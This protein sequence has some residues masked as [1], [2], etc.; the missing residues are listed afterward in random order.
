MEPV[1]VGGVIVSRATLHNEDEI[2]KKDI[3]LGDT[4][5]I[6]RAGDVIPE[7]IK[8]VE[9]KRNGQ[10]KIFRMPSHCPQCGSEISACRRSPRIAG[11]PLLSSSNKEH[12]GISPHV[13][14][15]IFE[16]LGE[17]VSAQLFDAD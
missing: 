3:R 17:K 12:T 1:S 11:Q 16:D 9:S 7:V 14:R 5:V 10:E 8:I 13:A 4:V 6:Q 2:I 15:W